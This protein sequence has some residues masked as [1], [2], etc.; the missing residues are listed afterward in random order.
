MPRTAVLLLAHGTPEDVSEIPDYLRN[1][2][3]G[4]AVPDSVIK[5]IQHRYGLIGRSP[6][7]EIT[8]RQGELLSTRL[9]L[10]VYVGM[11]NWKPYIADTLHQMSADGIERCVAVCLAPQ[12]SRTS[13]GLYRSEVRKN[14]Q[15]LELDFVESWH[16]HPLLIAAFAE[17]LESA[18]AQHGRG[19]HVIFTAHSV[20]ARTIAEG[21]PY[22]VQARETGALVTRALGLASSQWSFAF[23]SQGIASGPWIG[24]TVEETM[25]SLKGRGHDRVLI[26]PVGFVCDHV[27]VL[28]DIDVGFRYYGS[29]IGIEV[30]RPESLNDSPTFIAALADLVASRVQPEATYVSQVKS[31]TKTSRARSE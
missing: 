4:R 31:D 17:R 16:D 28:Y 23:Q 2:T 1:V 10:P 8:L 30:L 26:Q 21:D 20:P 22:E 15:D 3:G 5:E 18:R 7:T 13:V 14:A 29:Q 11:R 9:A 6:L 27:E 25:R 19:I 12:N 24:P